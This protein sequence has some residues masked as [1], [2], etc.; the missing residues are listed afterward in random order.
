[1]VAMLDADQSGKLGL[2]E[3]KQLLHSIFKWNN[4]FRAYDTDKSGHLSASELRDALHA[5]GFKLNN[6]LL[7]ALYH[8]YSGRDG[9]I[10]FVDFITCAVKIKTMLGETLLHS[11]WLILWQ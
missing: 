3:L 5:A 2:L 7:T 9:A 4:V 1:M 10:S 6:R 11:F 8:R